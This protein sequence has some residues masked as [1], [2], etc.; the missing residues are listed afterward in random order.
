M[1][2]VAWDS[3]SGLLHPGLPWSP[4]EMEFPIPLCLVWGWRGFMV[5]KVQ[6]SLAL[7]VWHFVVS[8]I[9]AVSFSFFSPS[10]VYI[11]TNRRTIQK[12]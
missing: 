9:L 4:S 5:G 1:A 3:G 6:E 8:C 2:I 10:C 12:G 11:D 7:A